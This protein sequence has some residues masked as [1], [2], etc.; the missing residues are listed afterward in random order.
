MKTLKVM[1]FAASALA[2][3]AA[4]AATITT[5][6]GNTSRWESMF[7]EAIGSNKDSG[8][9]GKAYY[10]DGL[11][12][13]ADA[14]YSGDLM[15]PA[16]KDG[17]TTN[18]LFVGKSFTIKHFSL[19]A[20]TPNTI[21]FAQD[22]LIMSAGC[23]MRE[24]NQTSDT[25]IIRG[26]VLVKGTASSPSQLCGTIN[27]PTMTVR[28]VYVFTNGMFRTENADSVLRLRFY[29]NSS[30]PG[31][32]DVWL[33]GDTSG[34]TGMIQ[35]QSTRTNHLVFAAADAMTFPGKV[36]MLYPACV[37]AQ[38]SVTM[39]EITS[40]SNVDGL[41]TV[42]AGKT[43]TVGN[44][45]IQGGGTID[46]TCD[47]RD[48]QDD[49]IKV[50]GTASIAKPVA[51]HVFMTGFN[52]ITSTANKNK[53]GLVRVP[54]ASAAAL[55]QI[56]AD[57][58][59][60]A[61]RFT[62]PIYTFTVE[63]DG[64]DMVLFLNLTPVNKDLTSKNNDDVGWR[65]NT[66][67]WSAGRLPQ[68]NDVCW[69]PS[70]STD[71]A[72]ENSTKEKISYPETWNYWTNDVAKT[73]HWV[74]DGCS[75][76]WRS[77][78]FEAATM[79]FICSG[80]ELACYGGGYEGKVFGK[81]F[82]KIEEI[83]VPG[84]IYVNANNA[85]TCISFRPYQDVFLWL[86]ANISGDGA[87][88]FRQRGATHLGGYTYLSGDNSNFTG[89]M[90][91]SDFAAPDAGYDTSGS[92]A[93]I[94]FSDIKNLGGE[95]KSFDAVA[96]KLV[97][98]NALYPL[99]DVTLDTLTR[100]IAF[101]GM[102]YILMDAD[103]TLTVKQAMTIRGKVIMEGKGK[104]VLAS[105]EAQKLGFFDENIARGD[106]PFEDYNL[107]DVTNG[108]LKVTSKWAAD[109]FA[110]T[111]KKNGKLLVGLNQTADTAY[112]NVKGTTA[113]DASDGKIP[114]AFESPLGDEQSYET[115]VATSKS[116]LTFNV[117]EKPHFY[118][119]KIDESTDANGN[120]VYTATVSKKGVLIFVR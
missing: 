75:L 29:N 96:L 3:S 44:L 89:E 55:A 83:R 51:L 115:V 88:Q 14:D 12:P 110:L 98:H 106:T 92:A 103:T 118:G 94:A 48:L 56:T 107:F 9:Y 101:R 116:Q 18:H 41:I 60:K 71:F 43:L 68:A 46:V 67:Y 11:A 77:R 19:Y 70:L 112:Y 7:T 91:T 72:D 84:G 105:A 31:T 40:D 59:N 42:G 97:G 10:S 102:T 47:F 26:N 1:V 73:L 119:V 35:C 8:W 79:E 30:Q 113:S 21:E 5:K 65:T 37:E 57:A 80:K 93:K 87:M 111:F 2:T 20:H 90:W 58:Y 64:D 24:R 23:D 16:Y 6:Q 108:Y 45:D 114:V 82:K 104:L 38:Q 32:C 36:R 117:V 69:V 61:N 63:E 15:S 4:M 86:N 81:T 28:P 120:Y 62:Y 17:S 74:F 76:A 109:G 50:T 99:C 22:G 78:V 34:F 54:K 33:K 52:S 95:R 85:S 13:H 25:Y 49:M 27:S 53:I 66:A 39:G 100:G